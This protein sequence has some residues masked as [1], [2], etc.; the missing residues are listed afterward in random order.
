MKSQLE[1]VLVLASTGIIGSA[2]TPAPKERPTKEFVQ[3][4]Y[5]APTRYQRWEKSEVRKRQLMDNIRALRQET[6]KLARNRYATVG[7]NYGTIAIHSH[8]L[9]ENIIKA[10]SC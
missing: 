10:K 6:K 8:N 9:I 1:S 3:S 5:I 4:T 2:Y 7:Y